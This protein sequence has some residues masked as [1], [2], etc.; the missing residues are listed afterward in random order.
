MHLTTFRHSGL[1]AILLGFMLLLA[2]NGQTP[3]FDC[4][5]GGSTPEAN[6]NILRGIAFHRDRFVAVGDAGTVIVSTNAISWVK[7][8]APTAESFYGI[9]VARDQFIALGSR[10]NIFLSTDGV[11]WETRATGH[12]NWFQAVAFGNDTFVALTGWGTILASTDARTWAV[13]TNLPFAV[14][15]LY[16]GGGQFVGFDVSG[17]IYTSVDG[18]NWRATRAPAFTYFEGGAYGGGVHVLVGLGVFGAE[19]IAR[20]TDGISWTSHRAHSLVS[21]CYGG[22]LFVGVGYSLQYSPD[23]LN[24]ISDYEEPAGLSGGVAYGMGHFAVISGYGEIY[25]ATHPSHWTPRRPVICQMQSL[26]Q[27]NSATV[28]I[29]GNDGMPFLST[30]G[31]HF[32]QGRDLGE[33]LTSL[34]YTNG[35]FVAAGRSLFQSENGEEWRRIETRCNSGAITSMS[36]TEGR[37]VASCGDWFGSNSAT[38]WAALGEEP[39]FFSGL[40]AGNGQQVGFGWNGLIKTSRDG[41]AW[42]DVSYKTEANLGPGTFQAGLYSLFGNPRFLV[43]ASALVS[44]DGTNWSDPAVD[45]PLLAMEGTEVENEIALTLAGNWDAVYRLEAST[46]LIEW[47]EAGVLA[48]VAGVTSVRL[49][50]SEAMEFFRAVRQ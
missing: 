21:I 43:P 4:I 23:G 24:W 31:V 27:G 42:Q 1:I 37:W 49:S 38:N 41:V 39:G 30:D 18:V 16:F 17:S 13:T 45:G 50:R 32:A 8:P 2:A 10:S 20:S 22:G 3:A 14:A 5:L 40:I 47:A 34:L 11:N 12:T 35:A 28:G 25:T 29:S 15:G 48:N 33:K 26:V 9:T 6:T 19:E 46:N 44:R 36:Y 7:Q